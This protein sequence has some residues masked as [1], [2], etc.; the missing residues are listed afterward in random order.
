[1]PRR[2]IAQYAVVVGPVA[3]W[4]CRPRRRGKPLD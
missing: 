1:M 3:A 4:E 2:V